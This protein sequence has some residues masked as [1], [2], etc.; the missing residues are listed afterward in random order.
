MNEH[1]FSRAMSTSAPRVPV[2]VARGGHVY[3]SYCH[4]LMAIR[5][6]SVTIGL[7]KQRESQAFQENVTE[8]RGEVVCIQKNSIGLLTIALSPGNRRIKNR[9]PR[10]D[11]RAARRGFA[12][13]DSVLVLL[14]GGRDRPELPGPEVL[15]DGLDVL[16]RKDPRFDA[17]GPGDVDAQDVAVEIDHRPAAFPGLDDHVGLEDG[18]EAA[19]AAGEIA[20]HRVLDGAAIGPSGGAGQR[21]L[22]AS[23]P[24][25]RAG[26][27]A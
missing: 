23:S 2:I 18:R 8:G 12:T 20:A 17:A 5:G 13:K 27:P 4:G 1:R 22:V 9:R 25:P 7:Q 6:R 10:I 21:E 15:E 26:R 16:A 11:P 14:L 3:P 24:R 19:A